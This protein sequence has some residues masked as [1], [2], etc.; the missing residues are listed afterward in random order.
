MSLRPVGY[1]RGTPNEALG[2]RPVSTTAE[3]RAYLLQVLAQMGYA[4]CSLIAVTMMALAENE[5]SAKLRRPARSFE[6]RPPGQRHGRSRI[7]AWGPLQYNMGAWQGL[8]DTKSYLG[9]HAAASGPMQLAPW[10][11]T[12]FESIALPTQRNVL[13]M[14]HMYNQGY[15]DPAGMYAAVRI[16]HSGSS[17][18]RNWLNHYRPGD[19]T[20]RS[21][22]TWSHPWGAEHNDIWSQAQAE[23]RALCRS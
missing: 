18:L 17:R 9:G 23:I 11:A 20:A 15:R 16:L 14:R 1:F 19:N 5:S 10:E 3:G 12:D 21:W 8:W 7:T 22:R 2:L 13:L 4:P 6:N